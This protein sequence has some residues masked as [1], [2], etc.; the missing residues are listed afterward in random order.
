MHIKVQIIEVNNLF[1]NTPVRLKFLRGENTGQASS[2]SVIE[3]ISI[4]HPEVVLFLYNN[5]KVIKTS[6]SGDLLKR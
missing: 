6:G 3:K 4:S 2:V 1:Y 5:D